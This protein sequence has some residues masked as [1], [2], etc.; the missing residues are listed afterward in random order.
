LRTSYIPKKTFANTG[1]NS[2]Y[3]PAYKEVV[4]EDSM[5]STEADQVCTGI[6]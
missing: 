4:N 5:N 6:K 1:A 2:E 3:V